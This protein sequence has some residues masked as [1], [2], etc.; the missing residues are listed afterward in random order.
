MVVIKKSSDRPKYLLFLAKNS[1]LEFRKKGMNGIDGEEI[2][3]EPA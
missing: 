1:A 3:V 2:L